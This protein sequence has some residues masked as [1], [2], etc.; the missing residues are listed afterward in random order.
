MFDSL[1]YQIYTPK[2]QITKGGILARKKNRNF[3]GC[4]CGQRNK[5]RR[6]SC[7]NCT[8]RKRKSKQ[9]VRPR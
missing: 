9:R 7:Q 5:N 6:H 3:W 4:S 8:A 2:Q 1:K